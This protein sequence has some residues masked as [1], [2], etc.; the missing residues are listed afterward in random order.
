MGV[1]EIYANKVLG[2]LSI[3]RLIAGCND[4]MSLFQQTDSMIPQ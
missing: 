1:F 4:L 2:G 3:I